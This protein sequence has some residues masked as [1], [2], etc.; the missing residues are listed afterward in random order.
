MELFHTYP[1]VSYQ[2]EFLCCTIPTH[3][4]DLDQG[5][6]HGV[7]KNYVEFSVKVTK[8]LYPLKFEPDL[9]DTL[10]DIRYYS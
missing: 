7:T 10:P 6:S 1:D 3:M 9:F 8:I 4:S 5:P 2:S